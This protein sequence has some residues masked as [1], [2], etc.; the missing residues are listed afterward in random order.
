[1]GWIQLHLSTTPDLAQ[2]LEILLEANDSLAITLVDAADQPVFEPVRGE[3]PLWDSIILTALFPAERDPEKLIQDLRKS[4]HPNKL[5]PV[6]LKLLEDEDWERAWMENFK[7]LCFG[8]NLWICPS[9]A[10]A[11]KP[12]AVNIMLDP[13]LAFGTGTHP[14]TAL[15][16]RWLDQQ[17]LKDMTLIDYGCGSGILGLAA[18]LLGAKQVIGVDN[19]P[20]ALTACKN[21]CEKNQLDLAKFPVFLPKDFA[22]KIT[23]ADINPTDFLLAN[24]LAG[25]LIELAAYLAALVKPKGR[26]LL[27]GIL[28]EQAE[29]VRQA[30]EP[31]FEFEAITSQDG[32][33][34][35][36]GRRIP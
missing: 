29:S 30:Y 32:W 34:R 31:W 25:P 6:E 35:I 27:S 9:W 18:L 10:K 33:V 15:C 22:E 2:D 12:E 28:Q 11:P 3:T 16:L 13:G 1:M 23:H 19:D 17:E 7:P 24:I 8:E 5:P 21:N 14:T 26:I 36:V 4:Y 20:Q